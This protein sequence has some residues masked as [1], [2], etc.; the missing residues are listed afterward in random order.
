[1]NSIFAVCYSRGPNWVKGKS[2]FEQPL[3]AHLA[4]MKAP[5]AQGRLLLG[6]PFL[7]DEGGLVVVRVAGIDEANQIASDDPAIRAGV[8]MTRAH[9]W[10]LL[11]GETMLTGSPAAV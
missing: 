11:A 7:N 6:G 2:V 5:H 10:K 3:Q 8:M 1:M 9:P 4:Y